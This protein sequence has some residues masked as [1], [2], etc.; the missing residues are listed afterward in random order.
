M[1]NQWYSSCWHLSYTIY[2]EKKILSIFITGRTKSCCFDNFQCSQW[3]KW[4]HFCFSACLPFANHCKKFAGT[5]AFQKMPNMCVCVC[6]SMFKWIHLVDHQYRWNIF[7]EVL[8][9]LQQYVTL[10]TCVDDSRVTSP[11]WFSSS[12]HYIRTWLPLVA[13]IGKSKYKF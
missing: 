5:H 4:Q 6:L 3:S 7:Y 12:V 9:D 11:E 2:T 8:E 13:P 1:Y 10:I